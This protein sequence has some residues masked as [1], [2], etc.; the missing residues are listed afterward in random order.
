MPQA[1]KEVCGPRSKTVMAMSGCSLRAWDAA[2]IPAASPPITMSFV[3][4]SLLL[5]GVVKTL[6]PKSSLIC[7]VVRA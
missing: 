2:L 5:D 7:V 1:E 6:H 3:K 4:I